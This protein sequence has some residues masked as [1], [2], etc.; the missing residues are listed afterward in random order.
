MTLLSPR[1]PGRRLGL[2]SSR[3]AELDR[4]GVLRAIRDSAG[5]RLFDAEAVE[6]LRQ[7]REGRH[8][9]ECVIARRHERQIVGGVA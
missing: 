5:R 1:D 4:E 8:Q 7:I 2:T 9:T 6:A 3:L